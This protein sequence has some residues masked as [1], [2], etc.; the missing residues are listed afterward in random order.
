MRFVAALAAA[1]LSL[2][3]LAAAALIAAGGDALAQPTT[4]VQ[5]GDVY[6]C[7]PSYA[8]GVCE[9]TVNAGDAVVWEWGPGGSGVG[10]SHTTTNCADSFTLCGGPREWDSGDPLQTSGTF[11]HTFG[12]EDA[13][14]T[15]LYRCQIHPLEMRGRIAVLAAAEPSPSPQASP[16]ASAPAATPT[17]A[18]QPSAVPAGGTV[19]P[20]EGGAV[21]WWVAVVVGGMLIASAAVLAARGLRRRDG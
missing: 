1:G 2:I 7:D 15:F 14:Q 5:V 10:N 11:A 20:A 6:F 3:A 16:Q 17:P 18:A 19:P 13:G 12:A 4:T 9:T 8:G 21:L